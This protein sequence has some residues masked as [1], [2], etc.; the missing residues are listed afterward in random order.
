[1]VAAAV[2]EA[3][4]NSYREGYKDGLAK[5][6]KDALDQFTV[7]GNWSLAQEVVEHLLYADPARKQYGADARDSVDR[8]AESWR[9]MRTTEAWQDLANYLHLE[10]KRRMQ[11][12][13]SDDGSAT[14]SRE[15]L[16]LIEAIMN[17][18][19]AAARYQEQTQTSD[20]VD[21]V[22]IEDEHGYRDY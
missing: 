11:S 5:G 10:Y 17:I 13:R 9:A 18:P 7:V 16:T 4:K 8:L 2:A 15:I 6:A 12:L 20:P 3:N 19:V 21:A 22:V 1:L 14:V